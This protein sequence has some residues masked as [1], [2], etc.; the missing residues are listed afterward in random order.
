MR[1]LTT[2]EIDQV[3]AGPTPTAPVAAIPTIFDAAASSPPP[4]IGIGPG[5][6]WSLPPLAERDRS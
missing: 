3:A 4:R 2:Q 6:P 5:I 1:E